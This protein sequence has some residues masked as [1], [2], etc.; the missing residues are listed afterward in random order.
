MA[1]IL[2][3]SFYLGMLGPCTT[4]RDRKEIF[5]RKENIKINNLKLCMFPED[6]YYEKLIIGQAVTH[7]GIFKLETVSSC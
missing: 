4:T 3:N 1:D 6:T 5:N 7:S 2:P